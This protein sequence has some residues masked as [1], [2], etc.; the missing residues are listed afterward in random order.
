LGG[1][2]EGSRE[3]RA[4]L[5][6][7]DDDDSRPEGFANCWEVEISMEREKGDVLVEDLMRV[8]QCLILLSKEPK[9]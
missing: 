8:F 4:L 3:V 1:D 9:A 2:P 7:V 5:R 6:I